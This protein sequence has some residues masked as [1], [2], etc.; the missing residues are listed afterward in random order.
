MYTWKFELDGTMTTVELT[1]SH[2]SG[3]KAVY[4]DGMKMIET[5]LF[6]G[7]FQYPFNIGNHMLNI[8]QHGDLFE[9]RIN[10]QS[11]SHL[12]NQERTKRAFQFEGEQQPNVSSSYSNSNMSSATP[13]SFRHQPEYQAEESVDY[14]YG[15]YKKGHPDVWKTTPT[16]RKEAETLSGWEEVKQARLGVNQNATGKTFDFGTYTSQ[17]AVQTADLLDTGASAEPP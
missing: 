7:S 17:P 2:F 10:N 9:L 8:V 16:T 13:Q 1:N 4:K 3:K 11:F 15:G 5:Q 14:G 12:Y 6:G